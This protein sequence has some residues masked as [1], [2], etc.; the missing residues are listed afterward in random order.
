MPDEVIVSSDEGWLTVPQLP[1]DRL[2]EEGEAAARARHAAEEHEAA[3][4]ERRKK[5]E[6]DLA[7]LSAKLEVSQS[8][9][10][11]P[12]LHQAE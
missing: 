3:E 2:K 10:H 5:A 8:G 11:F 6:D 1:Y 4:Q 9:T 12:S 7:S